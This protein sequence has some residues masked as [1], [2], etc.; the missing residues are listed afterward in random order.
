M[1]RI[2]DYPVINAVRDVV[3]KHTPGEIP[4]KKEEHPIIGLLHDIQR[5]VRR[6]FLGRKTY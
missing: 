5:F 1:G 4:P 3:R 2:W 6:R